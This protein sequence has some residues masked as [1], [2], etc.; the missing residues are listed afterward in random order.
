[1]AI[2]YADFKNSSYFAN[3]DKKG[4]FV[5]KNFQDVSG[6]QVTFDDY[7]E[8]KRILKNKGYDISRLPCLSQ[9]R[10][11]MRIGLA[12]LRKNTIFPLIV[13]MQFLRKK[14]LCSTLIHWKKTFQKSIGEV[15]IRES[16]YLQML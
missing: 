15:A 14:S 8:I 11:K 2:S 6:W 5:S 10:M 4:N 12:R 7:A 3:R 13:M 9:N 1:M 16:C